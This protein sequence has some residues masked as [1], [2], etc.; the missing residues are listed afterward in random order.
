[1]PL[2]TELSAQSGQTLF[3]K[4]GGLL[5]GK[6]DSNVVRGARLSAETHGIPYDYLDATAIRSRFPGFRP[7]DGTVGVL[8]HE[9]GILFPEAAITA[10][11]QTAMT[12][13]ATIRPNEQLISISPLPQGIELT[14]NKTTYRT[15]K[16]TVSAGACLTP[17]SPEL[18]LPLT[19]RRQVLFWFGD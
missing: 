13:G 6:A 2:W 16:L 4:T 3:Q 9:A 7:E 18:T 10:F 12:N 1:Y 14:T 8:E 5:L 19:I 15:E 17:L 11:L